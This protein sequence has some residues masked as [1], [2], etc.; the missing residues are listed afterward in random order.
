[1][2]KR[3]RSWLRQRTV[4]RKVARFRREIGTVDVLDLVGCLSAFPPD[5]LFAAQRSCLQCPLA[6][7]LKARFGLDFNVSRAV[8]VVSDGDRV[9]DYVQTPMWM[10]RFIE[11]I[12][13]VPGSSVTYGDALHV[14]RVVRDMYQASPL[15]YVRYDPDLAPGSTTYYT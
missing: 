4:S 13:K 15:I 6:L 2:I 3:I 7:Y 1:M 14:A 10:R 5:A 11:L 8:L 9:L 12:D